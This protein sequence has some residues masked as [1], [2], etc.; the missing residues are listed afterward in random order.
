V[1]VFGKNLGKHIFEK[2]VSCR[3]DGGEHLEWYASL[4][5]EC[6]RKIVDRANELY[7]K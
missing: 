3:K 1:L 5:N 2:W 6:R 7:N 4:D